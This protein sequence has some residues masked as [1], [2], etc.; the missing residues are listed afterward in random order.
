MIRDSPL[1]LL[2]SAAPARGG[3]DKHAASEYPTSI[4]DLKRRS[5]YGPVK[6]YVVESVCARSRRLVRRRW[7]KGGTLL[8]ACHGAP[9]DSEV[10][11]ANWKHAI[12]RADR[13]LDCYAQKLYKVPS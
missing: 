6:R 10:S 3:R 13:S 12:Y 11:N 9:V 2:A 8:L 1:V 4:A 5:E 7:I